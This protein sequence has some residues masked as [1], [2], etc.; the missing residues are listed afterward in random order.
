[1]IN[2]QTSLLL[3]IV[4]PSILNLVMHFS[5]QP[6]IGEMK[7]PTSYTFALHIPFHLLQY[8]CH[9]STNLHQQM[10]WSTSYH[11]SQPCLLF[12]VAL[13]YR[14]Y[15]LAQASLPL[16]AHH[17]K[18]SNLPFTLATSP[19]TPSLAWSSPPSHMTSCH[20]SYAISLFINT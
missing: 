11:R 4:W 17:S 9:T 6:L 2:M 3:L 8:W 20:V 10:I 1:M 12:T 16:V 7:C 5:I 14:C 15:V 19:S 13:V 18:A